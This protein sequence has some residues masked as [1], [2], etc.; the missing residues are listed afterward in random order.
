MDMHFSYTPV[1]IRERK[2]SEPHGRT[3]NGEYEYDKRVNVYGWNYDGDKSAD[4]EVLPLFPIYSNG[5]NFT[6]ALN[7]G[8][9]YGQLWCDECFL[10]FD[11]V[12]LFELGWSCGFFGCSVNKI[13]VSAGFELLGNLRAVISPV[14]KLSDEIPLGTASRTY[15][16]LIGGVVPAD[17]ELGFDLT[18]DIGFDA[19]FFSYEV[20]LPGVSFEG[21]QI[22]GFR[23]T[24]VQ[25][26]ETISE[27]KIDFKLLPFE[28]REVSTDELITSEVATKCNCKDRQF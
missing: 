16:H 10:A 4:E 24:S 27:S 26:L 15:Y 6:Q 13:T 18:L 8:L 9:S 5:S 28:F 19:Q 1:P 25:G 14:F 20:T 7:N 11:L 3:T 21:V 22:N 17:M 12:F 2:H 23:Y